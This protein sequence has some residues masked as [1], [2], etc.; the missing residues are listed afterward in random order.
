MA[1]EPGGRRSRY[2]NLA[3]PSGSRSIGELLERDLP[4]MTLAANAAPDL[5]IEMGLEI[6][7]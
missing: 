6:R 1:D 7:Q 5:D 3:R 2:W 4:L